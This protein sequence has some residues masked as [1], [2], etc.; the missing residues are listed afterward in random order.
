MKYKSQIAGYDLYKH[1]KALAQHKKVYLP[2]HFYDAM[3]AVP[4][5]KINQKSG[6]YPGKIVFKDDSLRKKIEK[7]TLSGQVLSRTGFFLFLKQ[8]KVSVQV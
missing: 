8:T 3:K 6:K 7:R 4:P 2:P 5:P 1:Y